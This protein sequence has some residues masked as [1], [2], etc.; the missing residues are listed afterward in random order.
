MKKIIFFTII[1]ILIA[2]AIT[3]FAQNPPHPNGGNGS[4][5]GN[6]R[7]HGGQTIVGGLIEINPDIGYSGRKIYSE[8]EKSK[9]RQDE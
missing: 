2:I 3:T 6:I 4:R 9:T 5:S 1:I 8:R 7:V